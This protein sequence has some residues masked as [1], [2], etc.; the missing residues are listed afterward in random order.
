MA[1]ANQDPSAQSAER[2]A[3]Q[4][5][6]SLIS[7]VLAGITRIRSKSQTYL[8]KYEDEG[9]GEY[10]RR[11][12]TAPWRPEFSDALQGLASK[13]F[14]KD[15]GLKDGASERMKALTEDIDGRG[16]S[17]TAFA[18][19]TFRKAIAKGVHLILVDYP[20]MHRDEDGETVRPLSKAEEDAIGARPYWIQVQADDIVALYTR[21]D[22]GR[23]IIDHLR[24]R[25]CSVVRE[26]F[27]EKTIERIRVYEPG[28]WEVYEKNETTKRWDRTSNGT[29]SRG[30]KQVASVPA[31]LFFTGERLGELQVKPPLEEL[32]HVQ[33]E[34][35]QALSRQDEILTFA[36]SPMLTA[37]GMAQ[38]LNQQ[39]EPIT[40]TVGPKSI[41]FAPP[42]G[43]SGT[44]S[45]DYINPDAANI[46]QVR[47]HTQSIIADMRRLGMQPLTPQSGN[48]TATGQS[49]DA[50][51][52]HSAVQ[53]WALG[54][55]DA[56]E[57]AFVIT[58]EWVN[59]EP[60][61]EVHVSTDFSVVP[62]AQAPLQALKDARAA[63]DISRPTYLDGLR[64]FDVLPQDFDQEADEQELAE[65]QQGLEPEEP[66]DP[67]TG[68]PLDPSGQ[69]DDALSSLFDP[70]L[71]D[72]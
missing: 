49:I 69:G 55:K 40:V 8:P 72:A 21:W 32:A 71:L 56:I 35:Y 29:I 12:T 3:M 61:V 9:Q 60:T 18:A 51:K 19:E 38:P 57:Q 16:N 7:D 48:P 6:W 45:W 47:G 53:A 54:L 27:G 42:G 39:N 70:S 64:R 66:I 62:F 20:A 36:S 13:P 23:E 11:L 26:G 41:L 63:R 14:S 17:L 5:A 52:A 68:Q 65:E 67:R 22:A 10:S 59:E 24:I 37:N 2:K 25:E 46:E 34:L 4:A 30:S 50:A 33:I 58:A 43:D 31:V 15:V 44:P 1:D 28:V